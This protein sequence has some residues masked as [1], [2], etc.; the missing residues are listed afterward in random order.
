MCLLLEEER[1]EMLN[2]DLVM[3]DMKNEVG[4]LYEYRFSFSLLQHFQTR[5][6][7]YTVVDERSYDVDC[8]SDPRNYFVPCSLRQRHDDQESRGVGKPILQPPADQV[9][10]V[11]ARLNIILSLTELFLRS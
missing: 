7:T 11:K 3:E 9:L 1:K 2:E 10:E 5:L 6:V 4:E 8:D